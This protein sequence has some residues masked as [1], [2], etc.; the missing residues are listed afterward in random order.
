MVI[1]ALSPQPIATPRSHVPPRCVHHWIIEPPRGS[2]SSGACKRCGEHRAFPNSLQS[3]ASE[4][5]G[6]SPPV[7]RI[8]RRRTAALVDE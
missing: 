8:A 6:D 4:R 1:E 5:G 3:L 2:S 7:D